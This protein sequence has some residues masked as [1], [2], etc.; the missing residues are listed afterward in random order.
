[1]IAEVTSPILVLISWK[2]IPEFFSLLIDVKNRKLISVLESDAG[3]STRTLTPIGTDTPYYNV[4]MR[5]P[6]FLC[7][8]ANSSKLSMSVSHFLETKGPPIF[9]RARRLNLEK[10]SKLLKQSLLTY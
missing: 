9:T 7:P 8:E 6:Q 10:S 2:S 3:G 4:L 1:M 5:F